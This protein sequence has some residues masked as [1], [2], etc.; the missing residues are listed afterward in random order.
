MASETAS[1]SFGCEKWADCSCAAGGGKCGCGASCG[2]GSVLISDVMKAMET[3]CNKADCQCGP[4][5]HCGKDS[6]QC[7]G[8]VQRTPAQWVEFVKHSKSME[9]SPTS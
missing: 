8:N 2:C 3:E 6:C 7:S 4:Y 5:C 1:P 9:N